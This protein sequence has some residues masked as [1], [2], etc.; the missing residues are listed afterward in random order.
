M[1]AE[2]RAQLAMTIIL[3]DSLHNPSVDHSF[4]GFVGFA[5]FGGQNA[6][7]VAALVCKYFLADLMK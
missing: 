4:Y 2:N 5:A 6:L 1:V 3:A 7:M